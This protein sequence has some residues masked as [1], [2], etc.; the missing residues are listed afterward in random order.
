MIELIPQRND[1]EKWEGIKEF[2]RGSDKRYEEIYIFI[3]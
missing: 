1:I 2:F 3:L